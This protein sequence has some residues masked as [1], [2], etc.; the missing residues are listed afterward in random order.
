MFCNM[1]DLL[2]QARVYWV[3]ASAEFGRL[4]VLPQKSHHERRGR[5]DSVSRK[6]KK[7]F[8]KLKRK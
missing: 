7:D 6:K 5:I 4:P 2:L 8:A 1:A 3:L